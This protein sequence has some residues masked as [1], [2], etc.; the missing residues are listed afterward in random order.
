LPDVDSRG[1]EFEQPVDLVALRRLATCAKSRWS[2]FFTCFAPDAGMKMM[3]GPRSS[4]DIDSRRSA[5][6]A[7]AMTAQAGHGETA[8]SENVS[9]PAGQPIDV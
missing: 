2:R 1:A 4:G 8:P 6:P 5:M 9:P 3:P 7:G